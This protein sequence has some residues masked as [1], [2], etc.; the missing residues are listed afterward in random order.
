[1]QPVNEYNAK[2]I[3]I[4]ACQVYNIIIA[5]MVEEKRGEI[6]LLR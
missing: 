2:R 5:S 3:D 4:D 1:M 6:K